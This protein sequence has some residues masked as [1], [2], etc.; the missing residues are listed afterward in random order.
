MAMGCGADAAGT[1]IRSRTG[2]VLVLHP[3][4]PPERSDLE[5]IPLSYIN[6]RANIHIEEVR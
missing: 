3:C 5:P 6:N 2:F 1:G 4:P